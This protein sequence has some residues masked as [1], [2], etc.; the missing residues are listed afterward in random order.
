[1]ARVIIDGIK[2]DISHGNRKMVGKFMIWNLPHKITCPGRTPLCEKICYAKKAEVAYKD[3]Y[4]S[5]M[6]NLEA[7]R[8]D[9]FVDAIDSH[10]KRNAKKRPFFR[11]HESGDF[12]S[13]EYLDKWVKLACLNPGVRFLAFTKSF[14]LD[15]SA[16]PANLQVVYS[17]MPD[18]TCI[19]PLGCK[20]YAGDCKDM[21][22]NTIECPGFCSQCGMCWQLDKIKFNVH[23]HLH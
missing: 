17:I 5:R 11:I 8:K 15:F 6:R 4:P 13:Q 14:G 18:T 19:H 22:G 12:Y 23:F 21:P 1:M 2:A 7:S 20:A 10:I 16:V 3:V 9:G